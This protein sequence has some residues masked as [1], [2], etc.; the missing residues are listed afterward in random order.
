MSDQHANDS[1]A[2]QTAGMAA[3]VGAARLPLGIAAGWVVLEVALRRGAVQLLGPV[4]GNPFAVDW[5]MLLVGFPLMGA[6]LSWVAIRGGRPPS[7]WG[8]DRSLWAVV[9]GGLGVVVLIPVALVTIQIDAY[10]FGLQQA[11]S[12]FAGAVAEV[13]RATPALAVLLL[14]GNGVVVPIVEEQVWR[15]VVQSELVETWGPVTGIAVTALLFALKHVVVDLSLVRLTTL[16][17]GGLVLG[18][19]RHRFGTVSSTVSHLG[20]NLLSTAAVVVAALG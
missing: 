10:L 19:I 7:E 8:Y 20:L 18:L 2:E 16:V 15:G 4:V 13:L 1:D 12:A 14:L 5:T 11:N 9:A 3:A 6:L 17:A